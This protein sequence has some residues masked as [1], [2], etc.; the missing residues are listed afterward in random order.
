[1]N[2]SELVSEVLLIVKRP[3]L[4]T[5]IE[6]AVRAATLKIHHTDFYYPDLVEVPVQFT[7]PANIQNFMPTDILPLF[8]KVKY[9][10]MWQGD[11]DGS[12]GKFLTSIQIENSI[13][14]YGYIKENVFYMA[15]QLLQIRASDLVHRVLFGCYVHPTITPAASYKSWIADSYPYAI[16]Y[17]AAR[18]IF[19]SIGYQ[20][21]AN[22]Y[23]GLTAEVLREISISSIDDIPVT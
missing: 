12:P 14:G 8:R 19:R 23:A 9:I 17:E 5:R 18:T 6:S 4:Q 3:D 21:Q 13:D 2:F 16:I 7:T 15:G 20:E 1:M 11:V 22:E 10:R